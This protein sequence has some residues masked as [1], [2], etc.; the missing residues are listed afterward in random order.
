MIPVAGQGSRGIQTA[1]A[2]VLLPRGQDFGH[3]FGGQTEFISV[4]IEPLLAFRFVMSAVRS[5][6]AAAGFVVSS[7]AAFSIW[8]MA[9]VSSLVWLAKAPPPWPL[10]VA[11]WVWMFFMSAVIVPADVGLTFALD[12]LCREPRSE[13][14][15]LQL[16]LEAGEPEWAGVLA[17]VC[18]VLDADGLLEPHA[19]RIIAP[20][21]ST[22]LL[23]NRADLA[24]ALGRQAGLVI[25]SISIA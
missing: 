17:V 12:R 3:D 7:A 22:T 25:D 2:A 6:T 23:P 14:T 10:S 8:P 4:I 18:I 19:A 24:V 9:A 5:F 15:L 21:A 13:S 11:S 16:T 20:P 1:C